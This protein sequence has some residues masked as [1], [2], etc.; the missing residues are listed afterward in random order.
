MISNYLIIFV[1]SSMSGNS[2]LK[3][4]RQCMLF[5]RLVWERLFFTL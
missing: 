3:Y 4:L 1:E 2:Q 5:R